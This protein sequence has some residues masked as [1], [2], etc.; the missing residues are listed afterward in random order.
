MNELCCPRDGSLLICSSQN[1]AA[2]QCTSCGGL[3]VD[4]TKS[5]SAPLR[6]L[7]KLEGRDFGD[8]RCPSTSEPMLRYILYGAEIDY[9]PAAQLVWLDANEY[10][11]VTSKWLAASSYEPKTQVRADDV[12]DGED[13]LR[14]IPDFLMRG[15]MGAGW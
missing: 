13:F 10:E 4:L 7:P 5:K 14:S 1:V 15:L 8:L 12:F 11:I 3:L 9:S 2:F 6:E